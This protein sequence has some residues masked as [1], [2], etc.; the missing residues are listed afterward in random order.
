VG[1][2]MHT[3]TS[4]ECA[5][6]K[7][8]ARKWRLSLRVLLPDG[9]LGMTIDKWLQGHG[10]EHL[11]PISAHKGRANAASA[12]HSVPTLPT[13]EATKVLPVDSAIW[14]GEEPAAGVC[15]SV[16]SLQA[17]NVMPPLL[18]STSGAT[19]QRA[20]AAAAEVQLFLMEQQAR[21]AAM[22]ALSQQAQSML[23]PVLLPQIPADI[24][25]PLGYQ[26]P[27]LQVDAGVTGLALS[28][29]DGRMLS[30]VGCTVQGLLRWQRQPLG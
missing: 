2:K 29:L 11:V 16:T 13:S 9:S 28:S 1:E 22:N 12:E 30:T 14:R 25:A 4:F 26:E 8:T 21:Q 24:P 10:Y 23:V 17:D 19:M 18:L 5:A 3:P 15:N 6:G 27:L 7:I 20:Q